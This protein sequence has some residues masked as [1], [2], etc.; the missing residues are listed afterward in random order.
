MILD[1]H[2]ELF[3]NLWSALTGVGESPVRVLEESVLVRVEE[4]RLEYVREGG[5]GLSHQV[6]GRG[7]V[8]GRVTQ[9]DCAAACSTGVS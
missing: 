4:W 1:P 2:A 8:P 3:R 6:E 9:G 5:S 7:R